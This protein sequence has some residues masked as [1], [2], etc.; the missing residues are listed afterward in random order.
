MK[1]TIIILSILAGILLVAFGAYK[2]FF[3]SKVSQAFIDKHN[4]IASLEKE[5]NILSDLE[6]MPG[7]NDWEDMIESEKFNEAL[8]L[9][10]TALR[11][12][13]DAVAKSNAINGKLAELKILSSVISDAKVKISS[14]KFIDIAGKE[15]ATRIIYYNL[16]IQMIEKAKNIV[17]LFKKNTKKISAADEKI[18]DD[19]TKQLEDLR[20]QF[21]TAEKEL[22]NIQIQYK[23]AEKEFFELAGLEIDK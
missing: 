11:R 17:I 23:I 5:A 22:N 16:Q 14:D 10:E 13:R 3:A 7:I 18:I 19:L 15:N 8:Q 6:N 1:K 12:K 21:N 9:D 20:T 2:I 4:E